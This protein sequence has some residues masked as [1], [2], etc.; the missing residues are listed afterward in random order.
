MRTRSLV[1][2]SVTVFAMSIGLVT[3]GNKT[4]VSEDAKTRYVEAEASRLCAV[5]K[6][7]Y[8]TQQALE[9]SF[10][11]ALDQANLTVK[12]RKA[13]I[14]LSDDNRE[15]RKRISDRYMEICK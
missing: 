11:A 8:P 3:C 9:D 7:T 2:S 15:F 12:E 10:N 5:Q 1:V 13:L 6:Q 14:D 4:S